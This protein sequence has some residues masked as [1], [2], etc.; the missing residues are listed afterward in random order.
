M[1]YALRNDKIKPQRSEVTMKSHD[2]I[3]ADAEEK[4]RDSRAYKNYGRA[5]SQ[6]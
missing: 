1:N 6:S 3:M 5:S 4:H 2:L